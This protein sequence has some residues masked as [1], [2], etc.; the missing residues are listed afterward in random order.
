MKKYYTYLFLLLANVVFLTS[1]D[2]QTI[3]SYLQAGDD[4]FEQQQYYNAMY[5]YDAV[6]EVKATASN[7]YKYAQAAR[8]SYAYEKAEQAYAKVIELKQKEQYPLVQYYYGLV[9]KQN[10][11]YD[12]AK[13]AYGVFLKQYTEVDFYQEKAQ[14]EYNSCDFAKQIVQDSIVEDSLV[15]LRLGNNINTKYSDFGAHLVDGKLYYSSLSYQRKKEK[16]E[17]RKFAEDKKRVARLLTATHKENKADNSTETTTDL[18]P[19]SEEEAE[20]TI[21]KDKSF[22]RGKLIAELND[23]SNH[24]ANST[25]SND[26]KTLYFTRCSGKKSDSL[27]CAIYT[28]QLQADGKWSALKRLPEPINSATA[29]TTH[30]NI[31]WDSLTQTE[32]LYFASDREGGFGDLDIWKVALSKDGS[33]ALPTNLG[34]TINTKDA[35]VTPFYHSK[36]QRLYFASRWH[37]GLGGYDIFYSNDLGNSWTT[38]INMGVPFN[39]AAND[40]YYVVNDNDTSGYFA[41]NRAGSR[42]ITKSAC[43]NDIYSYNYPLGRPLY[44]DTPNVVRPPIDTVP[45][46]DTPTLV[47]LLP[48]DTIPNTAIAQTPLDTPITTYTTATTITKL[49]T[50]LPLRL[51]FHNDEPDSNTTKLTT[52]VLYEESY[53]HYISLIERYKIEYAGQFNPERAVYER[54]KVT[55]FFRDKVRG[56]Y[57]RTDEFI[58]QLAQALASGEKLKLYIRGYTSPKA[59][60][61]YNVALAHRRVVSM[62][63][64]LLRYKANLLQQYVDNGQLVI[65]EAMLGESVSP[66]GISDDHLDPQNSI[67]GID[68]SNERK[69]EISIIVAQ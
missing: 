54:D 55:N 57:N 34:S 13:Q 50:L 67:F 3:E 9:L 37:F 4:A 61:K 18:P 33:V 51:Y 24:T 1:V 36:E 21:P 22:R 43:C 42:T 53:A 62:R 64:Y 25:I 5:Y 58:E 65:K 69:A 60:E 44:F 35:E 32:W 11:K 23:K 2:A 31:A 29:T 56:E 19:N 27:H 7:Y 63:S 15:I 26:G 49:N 28:A 52:N 12:A 39:S 41:S 8:L 30:P 10:A 68:A 45:L 59:S 20:P 16:N 40:L 47:V 38:P 17:D 46:V 14:Q 48:P 66:Q 6:L